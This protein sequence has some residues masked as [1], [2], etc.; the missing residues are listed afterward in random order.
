MQIT[1]TPPTGRSRALARWGRL[2]HRVPVV[3]LLVVAV[4]TSAASC[5]D[6]PEITV[7]SAPLVLRFDGTV[8]GAPLA[9][10][11]QTY[12][13]PSAPEGFR[14]SRLSFFV[15]EVALL[16]AGPAG[17]LVTDVS[18]VEYVEFGPDGSADLRL[19]GVPTGEYTG[20]RMRLGITAE[21]DAQQPKDFAAGSPLARAEE[22]WVDWGS[23]V[24]L[25]LEGKTDTL[26]D[27]RPRF[28]QPFIYHLGR[29]A[30][31]SRTV[32]LPVSFRVA[33]GTGAE[34]PLRVDVADLLGLTG[35]NP[36]PVNGA[37]DH[38]NEFAPRLMDN[39]VGA[40]RVQP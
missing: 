1:S 23:Y 22:Y 32:E 38:R 36:L 10:E 34:V 24:F 11:S 5:D 8:A 25:K 13:A 28:D 35:A 29:A 18:E 27:A 3:A 4:L 31:H 33:D 15:S 9:L 39:F 30:E 16:S 2:L 19:A 26:V 21:Q 37:I 14:L 12:Q 6:E 17:A 7:G 20:L 40:L